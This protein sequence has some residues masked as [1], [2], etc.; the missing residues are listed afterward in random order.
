MWART[1]EA[2]R[3]AL[4]AVATA[5]KAI[6]DASGIVRHKDGSWGPPGATSHQ[7]L[8]LH[9]ALLDAQAN[10]ARQE[11][12]LRSTIKEPI[13]ALGLHP[14]ARH[15][16]MGIA[17]SPYPKGRDLLR[18]KGLPCGKAWR[19]APWIALRLAEGSACMFEPD[20]AEA[21]VEGLAQV[22][23]TL[24]PVVSNNHPKRAWDVQWGRQSPWRVIARS[25]EG[26]AIKAAILHSQPAH[27]RHAV[28]KAQGAKVQAVLRA[29]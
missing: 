1:M 17:F 20:T 27:V 16:C 5:Q 6:D 13:M 24:A 14:V 23:A 3:D 29:F 25:P 26:A 2:W 28:D 8:A 11:A 7:R 15:L 18:P 21:L 22:W 19:D 12:L 10:L 9:H 4:D